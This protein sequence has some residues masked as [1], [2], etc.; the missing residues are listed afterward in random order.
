M[1]GWALR[2]IKAEFT[3]RPGHNTPAP[4]IHIPIPDT[5]EGTDS[6]AHALYASLD[7]SPP[8]VSGPSVLLAELHP[9]AT[10]ALHLIGD[11]TR[12]TDDGPA[13]FFHRAYRRLHRDSFLLVACRQAHGE[14]GELLD[15]CGR[16]IA[17]A[18]SAGFV[19]RQHILLVHATASG[20]R[21]HPTADAPAE[22]SGPWRHRPVHSDLLLFTPA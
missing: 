17:L 18:R 1:P 11:A 13:R 12:R 20:G 9:D 7:T 16:L 14:D 6:Q 22:P 8:P 2:R 5:G 4:L 21:L 19:Y 10:R 15:P 3:R